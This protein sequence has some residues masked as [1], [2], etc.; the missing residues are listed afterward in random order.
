MT[1]DPGRVRLK[2]GA[3]GSTDE[4][5]VSGR[6]VTR[7]SVPINMVKPKTERGRSGSDEH[8]KGQPA[9]FPTPSAQ[10]PAIAIFP[11]W[12]TQTRRT[13]GNYQQSAEKEVGESVSKNVQQ[14]TPP[15]YRSFQDSSMSTASS[16]YRATHPAA[17]LEIP[18]YCFALR[19]PLAPY[20]PVRLRYKYLHLKRCPTHVLGTTGSN[21]STLTSLGF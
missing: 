6:D 17:P 2:L 5:K 15:M 7:P 14:R 18:D 11:P 20:R 13:H 8:R 3:L 9:S 16:P 19:H 4:F 1:L 10:N 12:P 21:I